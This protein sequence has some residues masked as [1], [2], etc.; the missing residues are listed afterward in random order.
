MSEWDCAGGLLSTHVLLTR[1]ATILPEYDGG[2]LRLA[3][4]LGNRLLP[5]FDTPTGIPLSWV[6][7]RKVRLLH[8]CLGCLLGCLGD[9]AAEET[10]NVARP[11]RPGV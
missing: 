3:I 9:K 11:K 2:L 7:L 10:V 4:D 8:F 5:A 6:N 1:N